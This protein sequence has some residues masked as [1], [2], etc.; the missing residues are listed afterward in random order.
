MCNTLYYIILFLSIEKTT[1]YFF[2]DGGV[3]LPHSLLVFGLLYV[4][5]FG[6][7]LPKRANG[8]AQKG[9]CI[10]PKGQMVKSR[11]FLALWEEITTT[12]K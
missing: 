4:I 2:S 9:K 5:L 11:G 8:Y 1:E 12:K 6:I 7:G 3:A 10:L